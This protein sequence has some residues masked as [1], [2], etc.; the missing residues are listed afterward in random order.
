M[1]IY[2]F[3]LLLQTL[4]QN[5][6]KTIDSVHSRYSYYSAFMNSIQSIQ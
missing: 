3:I 2:I 1:Y 6:Y 4:E 5:Y